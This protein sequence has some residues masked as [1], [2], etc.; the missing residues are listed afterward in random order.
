MKGDLDG[1]QALFGEALEVL[2]AALGTE[3][4]HYASVLNNIGFIQERRGRLEAATG[5]YEAVLVIDRRRLRE[6]HPDIA[7]SAANLARVLRARGLH[8]EAARV[9]RGST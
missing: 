6:G 8:A 3:H 7:T 4:P 5:T 1:A 2:E 9:E